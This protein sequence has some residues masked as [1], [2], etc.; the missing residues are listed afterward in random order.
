MKTLEAFEHLINQ[1][2]EAQTKEYRDKYKQWRSKYNSPT[3]KEGVGYGKILEMLEAA[4]YAVT[5]QLT[6]GALVVCPH[7]G[8]V[9]KIKT[10][11]FMP[12]IEL[13]KWDS[14]KNSNIQKWCS[15]G[16]GKIYETAKK[17]KSKIYKTLK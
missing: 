12:L 10:P 13:H 16:S 17:K 7:C 4:G 14:P 15:M 9:V 2:W 6:T 5:V 3:S 1:N 11:G 8:Q